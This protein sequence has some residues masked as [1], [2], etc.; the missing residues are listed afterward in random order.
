MHRAI[1]S[2]V[3]EGVIEDGVVDVDAV[4]AAITL[5]KSAL[6]PAG[7]DRAAHATSSDIPLVYARYEEMR[8]QADAI[9]FDDFMPLMLKLATDHPAYWRKVTAGLRVLI[10][11]EYQ[12]VNRV[13][14]QLVELL[15]GNVADVMLVM[16]IR[17]ST[18]GVVHARVIYSNA[19]SR[20]SHIVML[21][22]IR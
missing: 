18:S 20:R 2:L 14:H 7:S 8:Q 6:I 16:M 13:Q 10:V 21:S 5:W 12:D 11:D 4:S 17:P 22:T 3:Q 1:Q 9:G 19:F 15:A